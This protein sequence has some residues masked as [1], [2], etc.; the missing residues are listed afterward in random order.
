MGDPNLVGHVILIVEPEIDQFVYNLQGTLERT[1]AETLIIR[2]PAK[3][4]EGMRAFRFSACV[5][6]YNYTSGALHAVID[7]L[8]GVPI[9]LYGGESAA[10]AS[11]RMVPH[12][13]FTHAKGD[14]I[15]TAL[16]RLLQS[17][18]Q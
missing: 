10:L 18:R 2:E 11:A 16:G 13:A 14:S 7:Y 3:A 15:V 12:L 8:N 6:N 9:L 5:M 4:V 1:G 17:A